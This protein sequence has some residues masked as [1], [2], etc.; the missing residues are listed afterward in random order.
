[1][2]LRA[3]VIAR[4]D[5]QRARHTLPDPSCTLPTAGSKA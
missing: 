3:A 4:R 1:V 5:A 2:M